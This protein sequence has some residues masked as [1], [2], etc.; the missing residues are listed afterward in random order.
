MGVEDLLFDLAVV[1]V[2][3]VAITYAGGYMLPPNHTSKTRGTI[4][5]APEVLFD[6]LIDFP[7]WP[8]WHK[9]VKS[10]MRL[11]DQNGHMVWQLGEQ[12]VEVVEIL[13]PIAGNPG[14]FIFR[15]ADRKSP[16]QGTWTWVL[17]PIGGAS[18]LT[19]IEEGTVQSPLWRFLAHYLFGHN[20][21]AKTVLH[22]L[23]QHYEQADF[24]TEDVK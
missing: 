4:N 2:V 19:I 12:V 10:P 9:E 24:K 1:F 6:Y 23:S 11:P 3:I 22:A 5:K 15:V 17:E 18:Q 8:R 20:A 16:F 21:T 13:K 7:K 14:H